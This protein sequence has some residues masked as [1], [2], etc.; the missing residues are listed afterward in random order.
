MKTKTSGLI[1]LA[2]SL[3]MSSL[4]LADHP[5]ILVTPADKVVI[6]SKIARVPWAKTGFTTLKARI[7]PLV[8]KTQTDPQFVTSRMLMNWD[9]HYTTTLVEKS[10]T[11]G[12]DGHAL[13]ATPRFEGARDWATDYSLPASIEDW[14][15]NNDQGGKIYLLNKK[16]NQFEWV[17]PGNTGGVIRGAHQR[18][19][20][21]AA[22]AAFVY[23][24]T[25][26][27]KYAKFASDILWTFIEG[28]A[29]TTAPQ[30]VVPDKTMETNIGPT[31]FEVIHENVVISIALAYDF[32]EPYLERQGRD[33]KS[34]Q[35]S[36]KRW[37]QRVTDGG[38]RDGNWNLN[39][40]MMIGYAGLALEPNAAYPDGH[41]RDYYA[42]IV[43]NADLPAQKGLTLVMK[44]GF[45][46]ATGLWPE[47][48]GY[49]FG[50][51]SQIIELASLLQNNPAG[52][53]VLAQPLLV[54]GLI[55]QG[56]MLHPN[57]LSN[58]VG[59]TTNTRM[60]VGAMEN[61]L[62]SAQALGD[63]TTASK[64]VPYLAREIAAG[65][66]DRSSRSD[67]YSLVR[68]VGQLP[69]AVAAPSASRS[70]WFPGLN[71][72]MQRNGNDPQTAL[73]AALFGTNGGHI[74][75]NGLA[76]ELYGAGVIQGADPGRGGSYWLPEHSEYYVSPVAHNT[77]VVNGV[78]DYDEYHS[79]LKAMIVEAVE[80]ASQQESLSPNVSFARASFAYEK[81]AA[82]QNRTLALIRT[83]ANSG[84]YFDVFRSKSTDA[85]G[86]F[87]DYLYH[88]MGTL[89]SISTA[90]APSG[91][92]S[93]AG[94]LKGYS[95]FKNEKSAP[96]VDKLKAT[97]TLDLPDKPSMT[98]WM[99][100]EAGRTLFAV[101]APQNNTIR[102]SIAVSARDKPMPTLV[103][104]Q[105]GEAWQ[106]PFV[107]VYE[108]SLNGASTIQNVRSARVEG[109][110]P[111]LTATIVEGQGY[112][113][114]LMQAASPD[115]PRTAEGATFQGDFGA[116]IER[117]GQLEELY[118]GNGHL[119]SFGNWRL[120]ALQ[121]VSA[122]MRRTEAGWVYSASAPITIN[123]QLHAAGQNQ[124]L[125]T[126]P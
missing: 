48:A 85:I 67:I 17:E 8:E 59:D 49:G 11:V 14:K 25:G 116:V 106:R 41:G 65:N 21:L 30:P 87:N 24:V 69:S 39:Q 32:L 95:Y 5:Q 90:L 105:S 4:A 77:V 7:D 54:Q 47:A 123:G 94:L 33:V 42:N 107:A 53:A 84:F 1:A 75:R 64:I 121:N 13:V 91:M 38:Y 45:D 28:F 96:L 103:V 56:E 102:D 111:T 76:I 126:T 2:S 36:L 60:N 61:L 9:T 113:V 12:G 110:A 44:E 117:N 19:L 124:K 16:T 73:S 114:H 70:F 23:W 74:H 51:S 112:R 57:G 37:A 81:P 6:Q 71:I 10:R 78:S 86:E 122:S 115:I 92:L 108:P 119:L 79:P 27:E 72:L 83:G 120:E 50:S 35:S 89:T 125:P 109:D 20:S 82:Q 104:R 66:Y 62:A 43:L 101:D 93:Q 63:T 26:D 118:L 100:H 58:G 3:I 97:F 34:I 55:N 40:A 88:N 99:P 80:P 46:P 18:I 31:T 68:F 29:A 15:P 52:R 98:L 22:D